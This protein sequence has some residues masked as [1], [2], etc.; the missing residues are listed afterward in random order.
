MLKKDILSEQDYTVS[1]TSNYITA[2]PSMPGAFLFKTFNCC[3]NRGKFLKPFSSNDFPVSLILKEIFINISN[4]GVLRGMHFQSP[5]ADHE[6]IVFCLSGKLHD[7]LLDL[8]QG[9]PN[10]G[11]Y[12]QTILS[13][14]EPQSLFIPKGVAHG[15][16]SLENE[17]TLLYLTSEPHNPVMDSVINPL[18]F[19]VQWPIP[20]PIISAR[21]NTSLGWDEYQTPFEFFNP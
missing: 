13:A 21:D 1:M 18:S 20:N 11:Q 3:D 14:A 17:T 12:T 4:R 8:R 19:G 2:V 6:K 5:P 9:S 16:Q 10:F 15:F 7:V